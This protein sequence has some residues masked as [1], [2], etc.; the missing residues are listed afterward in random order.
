MPHASGEVAVGCAYATHGFVEPAKRI[1]GTAQTRG[2]GGRPDLGA[3][4]QKHLFERLAIE[5]FA[6]EV[7]GD[8]AGGGNHKRINADIITL[9][10]FRSRSKV[11]HLAAGA[12]A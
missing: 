7:G 10:H 1:A 2:T 9:K 6:P 4:R 5:A 3:G 12:R 11:G 8:F